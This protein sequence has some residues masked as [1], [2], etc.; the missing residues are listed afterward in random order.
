MERSWKWWM[1]FNVDRKRMDIWCNGSYP[2][3]SK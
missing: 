3:Q 2:S 1:G